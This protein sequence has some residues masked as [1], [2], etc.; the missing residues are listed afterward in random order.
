M[1]SVE[2]TLELEASHHL[3][4]PR[5]PNLNPSRRVAAEK[6]F[7]RGCE[8]SRNHES[9]CRAANL[10]NRHIPRVDAIR[11]SPYPPCMPI[12]EATIHQ[13]HDRLVKPEIRN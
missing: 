13:P 8:P 4:L 3:L 2:I 7:M 5:R 10:Q 1:V 12:R 11:L 6:W 9:R